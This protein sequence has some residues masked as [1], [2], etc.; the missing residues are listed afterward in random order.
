MLSIDQAFC[1]NLIMLMVYR[2]SNQKSSGPMYFDAGES[3]TSILSYINIF[4]FER[5]DYQYILLVIH[6][7]EFSY[8]M[9][10]KNWNSPVSMLISSLFPMWLILKFNNFIAN[11]FEPSLFQSKLIA[12]NSYDILQ[13]RKL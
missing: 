13:A 10:N 9:V 7:S 12:A 8:R 2:T 1:E 5:I 6:E 3:C 11:F 4:S